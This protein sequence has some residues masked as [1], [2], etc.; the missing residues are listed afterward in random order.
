MP[1][2][3]YLVSSV[4]YL[5]AGKEL[6]GG[7]K[8]KF[9]GET[10]ETKESGDD[11]DCNCGPGWRPSLTDVLLWHAQRAKMELIQ[12][13]IKRAL[14]ARRGKVYDKIAEALADHLAAQA[15]RAEDERGSYDTLDERIRGI[16]GR[17]EAKK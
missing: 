10:T 8:M 15:E 16:L 17:K 11:C 1:F 3:P 5:Y 7:E 14:E 6:A 9:P 4:Y 2:Q 13:K 12:E